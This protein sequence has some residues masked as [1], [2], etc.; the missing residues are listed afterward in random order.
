M[1]VVI[2]RK[3]N[4][5]SMICLMV[6]STLWASTATD[7][8]TLLNAYVRHAVQASQ[9]VVTMTKQGLNTD[10]VKQQ[11]L[12]DHLI[13]MGR[14][15]QLLNMN[16]DKIEQYIREHENEFV[17]GDWS[18]QLSAL[19]SKLSSRGYRLKL[20]NP[21]STTRSRSLE[22]IKKYGLKG[23]LQL[24]GVASEMQGSK[25]VSPYSYYTDP[26]SHAHVMPAILPL[27]VY[28]WHFASDTF[29]AAAAITAAFGQE[30]EALALG[31]FGGVFF[32]VDAFCN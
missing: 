4:A 20:R 16:L 2:S 7:N 22:Q 15:L 26:M 31:A 11:I 23:Y 18:Q 28:D 13:R 3:L 32:F 9:D 14:H 21:D 30:P 5:L 27:C 10:V 25:W 8:K 19:Q 1:D 29:F 6:A 12:S 24:I 17:N